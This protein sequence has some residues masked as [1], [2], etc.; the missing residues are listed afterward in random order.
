MVYYS[1]PDV[2]IQDVLFITHHNS[3][4]LAHHSSPWFTTT[5]SAKCTMIHNHWLIIAHHDSQPLAQHNIPWFTTTGSALLAMI[6]NPFYSEPLV[7]NHGVLFW[8]R[9]CDSRCIILSKWL[10]ILLCYSD[11]GVVNHGKLCW[12]SGC[13]SWY[14]MLSQWLWIMVSYDEPVVVNHGAFCGA[15]GCESWWDDS[16]PLAQHN[17]SWF[18]SI[19]SA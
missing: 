5:G 17:T 7:V 2:V 9:C 15:S 19:G 10:W 13:E 6:H 16:Q 12:A 1:E 3:Q 4:Q 11:S 14:V 8:A 18:T